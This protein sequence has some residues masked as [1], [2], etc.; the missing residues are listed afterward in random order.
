LKYQRGAIDGLREQ[1]DKLNALAEKES[2]ESPR[3]NKALRKVL[4]EYA[5]FADE[6]AEGLTD[7]IQAWLRAVERF[8]DAHPDALAPKACQD[9]RVSAR[10]AAIGP[11]EVL[12]ERET[13]TVYW[14]DPAGRACGW[15]NVR[16]SFN[17]VLEKRP[18]PSIVASALDA[19]C[20]EW[21]RF[22]ARWSELRPALERYVLE[23]SR[24]LISHHRYLSAEERSAYEDDEGELSDE[25]ILSAVER[26]TIQL[27]RHFEQPVHIELH[28]RVPWDDEHGIEVQFDA[29]GEIL[30]YD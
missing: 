3:L 6:P 24:G 13:P 28:F 21:D 4:A 11:Y 19:L 23:C 2:P 17:I 20:D 16:L 22:Q 1:L 8:R 14:D 25:K 9:E 26:G 18:G 15:T 30:R 7:E 12:Y 5:R 29:D 27:T 10:L